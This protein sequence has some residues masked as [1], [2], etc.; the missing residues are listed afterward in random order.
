M[1][2]LTGSDA[3]FVY[4]E[5]PNAPMHIGS[6]AI[7]DPSTAPG[8]F[9]RFKDILKGLEARLHLVK[10]F[11]QKLVRLPADIDNP[12]WVEDSDFDLEYH[13]RHIALPQP[14]DWR[15]LC[16][17]AAR[18]HARALD[19]SKP[20]WE[21]YIIEGLDN[22]EGLPPGCFALLS[23][24]HHA[25]IDGA[26]G[27]DITSVIHTTEPDAA[28]PP[29][30][31]KPWAGE[32][33]PDMGELLLRTHL[34][35]MAQPWRAAKVMRDAAPGWLRL[36]ERLGKREV[37]LDG[38]RPPPRTR[39]QG[40]ASSHRVVD[41]IDMPLAAV[42]AIRPALPGCT[43]NDVVLTIVGGGLRKYLESKGELPNDP[44]IVMAPIS[45]RAEGEKGAMGNQVTAMTVS[46]GTDVAD[47]LA[48]LA[49]VH[50]SAVNS[51]A[52]TGAVGARTLAEYSN[53]MP[54]A[55]AGLGA[56]LYTQLGLAE[57]SATPF[58]TVVTNVPGPRVPLYFA[59]A[60]LLKQYGTGPVYDGMGMIHPVYSYADD[61][62][63]SF[64][65]DRDHLPDPAFYAQCLRESFQDLSAAA[66]AK[67][68]AVQTTTPAIVGETAVEPP[69][70][71]GGKKARRATGTAQGEATA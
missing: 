59:G 64:T 25:A 55:L 24:I 2:Q 45:V 31:D 34:N 65:A 50:A 70:A 22:V 42:R 29:P 48:R 36:G 35:N 68:G 4:M 27:V 26:S 49:A 18:L 37:R 67:L 16:I 6:I 60:K 32:R 17:Q 33:T 62:F 38:L 66:A 44:L 54:S 23:K 43:I 51:K 56:R 30:P 52:L 57:R 11:R 69:K 28:A 10:S 1:Q 46:V 12:Y 53:L 63:L 7:Y 47:P 9:V 13:V 41:G 40:R 58:N 20:L 15:Q 5:Q 19:M 71:K 8:G 14:G 39:F 61:I 3:S 21:F